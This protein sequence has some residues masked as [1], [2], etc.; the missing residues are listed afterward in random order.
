MDENEKDSYHFE[1]GL[2]FETSIGGMKNN[3]QITLVN[4][5]ERF[6]VYDAWYGN[7]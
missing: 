5:I 6:R 2:K 1:C 3:G 7:N 4:Q